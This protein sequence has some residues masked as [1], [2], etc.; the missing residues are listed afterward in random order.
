MNWEGSKSL[1]CDVHLVRV[2]GHVGMVKSHCVSVWARA[3]SAPGEYGAGQLWFLLPSGWSY[4]MRHILIPSRNQCHCFRGIAEV[5]N[6]HALSWWEGLIHLQVYDLYPQ[7][8]ACCMLQSTIVDCAEW[9]CHLCPS[10]VLY[11]L[12]NSLKLYSTAEKRSQPWQI[13]CSTKR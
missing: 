9:H 5:G 4:V 2:V 13:I 3:G 6:C 12:A 1:E 7:S 11:F 8:G 10:F